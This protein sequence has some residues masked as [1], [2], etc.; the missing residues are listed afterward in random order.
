MELRLDREPTV[1]ETTF[2]RLSVDGKP[3]CFT[4][5]D[6]LREIAGVAV[7]V[8]KVQNKTA[9]SA[10]RYR[11]TEELSG[12]FGPDTMTV[13]GVPG[14][15]YVR[16]HG[17]NTAEDTDGCIIVGDHMDKVNGK[18]SG[19]VAGKVLEKLKAKVTAALDRGE[20]V[21]LTINNPGTLASA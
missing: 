12:R 9:I 15:T 6:T 8:W 2:G 14:F 21:W 4:L 5:E 1:L 3:E 16:I 7:S 10:G 18:I 11:V 20:E 19:A 13:Q 17:G